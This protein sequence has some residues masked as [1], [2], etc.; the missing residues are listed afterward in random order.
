MLK[1]NVIDNIKNIVD[2]CMG[3][4]EAACVATCQCIQM[5]KNI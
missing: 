2:N 3:A 1:S 4:E 5:P